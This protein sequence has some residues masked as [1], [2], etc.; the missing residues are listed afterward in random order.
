LVFLEL[1]LA[2][3]FLLELLFFA[4]LARLFEVALAIVWW[5]D[6]P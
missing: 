5:R 4:E 1:F 6:E 2:V 3:A